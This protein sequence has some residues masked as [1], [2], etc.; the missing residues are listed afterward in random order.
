MTSLADCPA[1]YIC[2]NKYPS[3]K[4]SWAGRSTRNRT[5][6]RDVRGSE[7]SSG[8]GRGKGE[9]PQGRAGWGKRSAIWKKK[10]NSTVFLAL[11]PYGKSPFEQHIFSKTSLSDLVSTTT[12]CVL[13]ETRSNLLR[14]KETCSSVTLDRYTSPWHPAQNNQRS[15]L[16]LGQS[17]P[18]W[19]DGA[20]PSYVEIPNHHLLIKCWNPYWHNWY[21][22]TCIGIFM[23][24]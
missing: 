19:I 15:S 13:P 4:V 17:G 14:L 7:F 8:V 6:T 18:P 21:S 2:T 16:S 22:C 24:Y 12:R 11:T 10:P 23:I 20:L 3:A 9:N 5:P 1:V